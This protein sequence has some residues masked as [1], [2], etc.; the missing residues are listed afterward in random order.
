MGRETSRWWCVAAG[1]GKLGTLA[2]GK[3][4]A[5]GAVAV[6]RYPD[7]HGRFGLGEYL[8]KFV[9]RSPLCT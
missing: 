3:V 8:V 9:A 7:G 2:L 4:F 5:A 6:L 1:E